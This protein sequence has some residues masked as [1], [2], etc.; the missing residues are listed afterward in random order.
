MEPL[1]VG[2]CS[3]VGCALATAFWYLLVR[4]RGVL[5]VFSR[6]GDLDIDDDPKGVRALRFVLAVALFFAAFATGAVTAF[7]SRTMLS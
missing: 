2:L 1:V 5:S 6:R 7:L 3:G 4:P